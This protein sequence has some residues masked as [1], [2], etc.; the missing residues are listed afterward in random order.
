MRA[1]V[2]QLVGRFGRLDVVVP[3]AGINGVRA[4]I[5]K[6]AIEE[7]AR[8]TAVNQQG[9]FITVQAAVPHLKQRGG[10][11]VVVSSVDGNVLFNDPGSAAYAATKAAQLAMVR[12]LAIELAEFKIRINAVLPGSIATRI[13]DNTTRKG[14]DR[15]LGSEVKY[16]KG[17]IPLTRG[18]P[19]RPEQVARA[20]LFLASDAADHITGAQLVVDG[21]QS[22]VS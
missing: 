18:K 11:I 2:E 8:V 7:V 1:A 9:T 17:D 14:E 13:G 21:G 22:L 12:V 20:I 15:I 16:P 6:I 4:P 10:S 3:N 19:G 5:D